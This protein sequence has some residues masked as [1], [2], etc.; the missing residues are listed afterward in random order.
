MDRRSEIAVGPRRSRNHH[1]VA[2]R[3]VRELGLAGRAHQQPAQRLK[4]R[5]L[6]I[7][8]AGWAY[9]VHGLGRLGIR[10]ERVNKAPGFRLAKLVAIRP[11]FKAVLFL[12]FLADIIHAGLQ[13]QQAQLKFNQLVDQLAS[14]DLEV[15]R[16]IEAADEVLRLLREA[17]RRPHAVDDGLDERRGAEQVHGHPS[18]E[19]VQASADATARVKRVEP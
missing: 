7:F 3:Q 2:Q 18:G 1:L 19:T 17:N 14:L 4:D 9:V 6:S 16:S 15:G 10:L 8:V 11:L 12:Y 5:G 13:R